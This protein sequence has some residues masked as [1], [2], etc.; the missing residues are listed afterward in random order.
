MIELIVSISLLIAIV[1]VLTLVF[2]S[3][4]G[5]FQ[6][7][8][9]GISMYNESREAFQI[10][11]QDIQNM[12]GREGESL[13]DGTATQMDFLTEDVIDNQILAVR[14]QYNTTNDELERIAE[15]RN[16]SSSTPATPTGTADVIA[17]RLVGFDIDYYDGTTNSSTTRIDEVNFSNSWAS[18]DMPNAIRVSLT[19]QDQEDPTVSTTFA[20]IY[21]VRNR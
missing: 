17:E 11:N 12:I 20:K 15:E 3:G 8:D 16:D 10:I 7:Y 5:I 1:Y 9:V 13:L 14:Y 4:V 18:T 19:I 2:T 21:A 6:K